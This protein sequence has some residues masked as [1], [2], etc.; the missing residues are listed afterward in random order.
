MCGF[1]GS[2][3]DASAKTTAAMLATIVHRGPDEH[4]TYVAPTGDVAFGHRRLSIID[5]SSGKQPMTNEDGTIWV[6]FNGE[7]YNHREIRSD[8]ER[9]GHQFVTNCDTEVLVHAYE[10]YGD[11]FISKLNGNFAF[12]IH[13]QKHNRCLLARDRTG[14]RPLFY[15][16]VQGK[17][18]FASELK[19]LLQVPGVSRAVD[20][21]A[22]DQYLSLRYSSGEQ[23]LLASCRRLP[24]GCSMVV[25]A[26]GVGIQ[27]YW[28]LNLTQQRLGEADATDQLDE[29]LQDSV[30]QRLMSDVPL[31]MYLSGGIDSNLILALMARENVDAGQ[32]IFDHF[33][34][35]AG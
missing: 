22:L 20:P 11:N 33:R 29:L 1:V 6:V 16:T 13:D 24:P 30:R 4:G 7:I 19:A 28:D 31:G 18:Y 17:L 15:T 5:L 21:Q 14:I 35:A 34:P 25:D 26:H 9:A 8:L 12:A 10:E 23:P 3:G 2:W 32:D 27:R